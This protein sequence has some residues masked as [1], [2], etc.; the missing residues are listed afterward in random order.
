[1][2]DEL[3]ILIPTAFL[4]GLYVWS[5]CTCVYCW[6]TFYKRIQNQENN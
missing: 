6:Y 5:I 2:N 4:F 1:M 3:L